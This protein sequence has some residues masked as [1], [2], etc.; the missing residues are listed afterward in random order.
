MVCKGEG[1]DS[2]GPFLGPP[3]NEATE[4]KLAKNTRKKDAKHQQ[5][6]L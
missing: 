3:A 5:N 1:R 6:K 4:A 2:L